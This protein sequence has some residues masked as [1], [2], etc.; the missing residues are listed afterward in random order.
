MELLIMQSKK[1]DVNFIA[2]CSIRLALKRIPIFNSHKKSIFESIESILARNQP[3]FKFLLS[4]SLP[5]VPL[6]K[7]CEAVLHTAK[8]KRH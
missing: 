2:I 8:R 7:L 5:R 6:G 3:E 4:P 1:Y